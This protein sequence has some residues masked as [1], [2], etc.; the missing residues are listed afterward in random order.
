MH[1]SA[2]ISLRNLREELKMLKTRTSGKKKAKR[3]KNTALLSSSR[4]ALSNA[5]SANLSGISDTIGGVSLIDDDSANQ[6]TG[7]N[8]VGEY[9]G[10]WD[11]I[12][13]YLT[14]H[15]QFQTGCKS[16]VP[17]KISVAFIML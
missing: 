13:A 17:L 11:S 6:R 10:Q 12:E 8:E 15:N 9:D 2:A 3:R 14:R 7:S 5:S 16:D 4:R 1:D